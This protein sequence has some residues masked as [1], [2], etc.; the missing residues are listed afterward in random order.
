[1]KAIKSI[2]FAA[3]L[4]AAIPAVHAGGGGFAGATEPTQIAN[5]IQLLLSYMEQAQQTITQ[6]NQYAS[7]LK[8]LQQLTPSST[9]DLAALK[10]WQNQNMNQTFKDLYRIVDGGQRIAYTSKNLDT[11]LKNMSPSYGNALAS[12][13]LQSAYKNWS[14]TTRDI[15]KQALTWTSMEAEEMATEADLVREL[16][17]TAQTADGQMKALTA[18]NRIGVAM[19]GQM[20]KLRT[21]QMAQMQAQNMA[22]LNTQSRQEVSDEL[23]KKTLNGRCTRM[24]TPD[25]ARRG[26]SCK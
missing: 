1:M 24:L 7:M 2:L 6:A 9:L 11:Q 4:S 8:N 14:E 13:D 19:I 5:N 26:T 17:N 15:T 3:S 23:L 21:L 18:G 16:S 25:E 10:L 22:T 20:Q 12:L